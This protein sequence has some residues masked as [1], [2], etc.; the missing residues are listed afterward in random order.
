[1]D[2]IRV[3]LEAGKTGRRGLDGPDVEAR[4]QIICL[5]W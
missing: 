5:V 1:M 4:A 2:L 3:R